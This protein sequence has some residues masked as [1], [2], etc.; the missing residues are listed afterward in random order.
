MA[1][2]VLPGGEGSKS[3]AIAELRRNGRKILNYRRYMVVRV[4]VNRQY[5]P[6]WHA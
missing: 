5:L 4:A 6:S 2:G 3:R 1:E